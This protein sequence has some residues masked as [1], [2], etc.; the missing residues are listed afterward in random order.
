MSF[1][2]HLEELRKTLIRIVAI[3]G[4]AFIITSIYV[5][6]ITEWLLKP[7][8]DSLHETKAGV[9]VYHSIF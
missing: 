4:V 2:E 5:D 8:R 9:I 3:L 6:Q 1:W 7:L